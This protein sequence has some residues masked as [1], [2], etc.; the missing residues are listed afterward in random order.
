[1]DTI[2]ASLTGRLDS[3]DRISASLVES[4]DCMDWSTD[5]GSTDEEYESVR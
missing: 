5:D 3:L 1:M 4:D 2:E